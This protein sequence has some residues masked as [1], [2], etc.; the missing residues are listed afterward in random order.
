[1]ALF[2]VVNRE[3]IVA[4]NIVRKVAWYLYLGALIWPWE[5]EAPPSLSFLISMPSGKNLC[6]NE[7][8][9]NR[10]TLQ[11]R[12]LLKTFMIP[13]K[14][15]VTLMMTLEDHYLKDVPYHNSLHAA[16][17]TQSTNVLL[18]TPALEVRFL[19]LS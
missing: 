10:P 5:R 3:K 2:Y 18:N 17:V 9:D 7:V 12:D 16:D 6:F 19:S 15:L 14:T 1:V 11:E 4:K 8:T 13:S